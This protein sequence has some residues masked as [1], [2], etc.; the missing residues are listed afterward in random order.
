MA[1]PDSGSLSKNVFANLQ[2]VHQVLQAAN[3]IESSGATIKLE[4]H[5]VGRNYR[6]LI[7]NHQ[8]D[9]CVECRPASVIGDGMHTIR[10]LFHL[11]NQEEGRGD[12]YEAHSPCIHWPL[13]TRAVDC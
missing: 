7:I 11:R 6:V 12:R 4:S 5:L 1:K 2:T 8:Y 3:Q 13:T 10:E 9:G